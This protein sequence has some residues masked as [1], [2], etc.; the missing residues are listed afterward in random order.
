MISNVANIL[1][2]AIQLP[3]RREIWEWA[4]GDRAKGI[5]PRVVFGADTP[6]PGP[7][8]IANSPW[9]REFFRAFKNPYV[10]EITAVMPPQESGKTLTGEI[11]LSWRAV[12]RPARMA[13]NITTNV[14]AGKLS[15]TRWEPL[16]AAIPSLAER[17]SEDRH[18]KKKARIIFRDGSYLLLQGAEVKGNRSSDSIQVQ[19]NDEVAEWDRP[20]VKEMHG[21]LGAY[22]E[23]CK[24]MN[25]SVGGKRGSELHERFLA[26]NQGEWCHRCPH[27]STIYHY[28]HD[29]RDP[30]CNIRY[31]IGAA[32]MHA[33]GRID[34]R[35]F[36]KTVHV[37]CENPRCARPIVYDA[38]LLK[39]LN[40]DG[41]Y[42]PANPDANPEIVSLHANAFAIGRRPWHELLEPWV[43]LNLRGGHFAEEVLR[44][45]ICE[46]LAE[47]WDEKPIVV[48]AEIKTSDYTRADVV[49]PGSVRKNRP[50]EM[51]RLMSVDNQRGAKGDIPHR[52]FVARAFSVPD[53]KGLIWTWLIDCGRIDEWDKVRAKQVEL[54]I[55][56]PTP[57]APGPFTVVD[58]GY[59]PIDVYEVC[60][61]YRWYALHAR[62][63]EE[64]LHSAQSP[65]AGTRQ[66]FSEMRFHDLGFGTAEQGRLVTPYLL[67]A[68]DKIYDH[69]AH[70]RNAGQWEVPYD[71]NTFCPEYAQHMNGRHQIMEVSKKS[72]EEKRRW[73]TIAGYPD[74]MFTCEAQLDV[75]GH[76]AGLYKK[77]I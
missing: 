62:V 21:R 44:T 63:Q 24:K 67:W 61:K 54:G 27:C 3:D 5:E 16:F 2:G 20:W 14:K 9:N 29:P 76:M 65:M 42:V 50:K 34:L 73:A 11:C 32:V 69:L 41:V 6:Y 31:D 37:R 13:Y 28:V 59:D 46:D 72:G 23:T 68:H 10:R 51:V 56:D 48:A 53:A 40:A 33:D 45:F 35:A 58:A 38:G 4:H 49:K 52:W 60:G 66:L 7:Y 57:I 47:F 25:I 22:R 74:H 8:D 30:R 39:Q 12:T 18:L 17:F 36:A 26:G 75:I 19:L 70:L 55:P 43:R 15:E 77:E 71:I 64:F 1:T